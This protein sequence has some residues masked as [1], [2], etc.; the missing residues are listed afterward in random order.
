MNKKNLE[1]LSGNPK[2][3]FTKAPK[4]IIPMKPMD[5]VSEGISEPTFP[6]NRYFREKGVEVDKDGDPLPD[7]D[8]LKKIRRLL[9][10]VLFFCIAIYALLFNM[11]LTQTEIWN[12]T[13]YR[14]EIEHIGTLDFPKSS[15]LPPESAE[16]KEK[17]ELEQMI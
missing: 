16:A 2:P 13:D 7:K 15:D 5:I 9:W 17:R 3:T 6:P 11:M 12:Y 8:P 4:P 14:M 1:D 10:A